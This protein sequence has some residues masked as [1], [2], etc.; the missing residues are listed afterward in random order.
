MGGI[1]EADLI[2]GRLK[3]DVLVVD[4]ERTACTSPAAG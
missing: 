4:D 2:K 1:M 3:G